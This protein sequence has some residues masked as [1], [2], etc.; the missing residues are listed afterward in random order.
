[1]ALLASLSNFLDSKQQKDTQVSPEILA[2]VEEL[3]KH[4]AEQK[5]LRDEV[6]NTSDKPLDDLSLELQDLQRSVTCILSGL[7]RQSVKSS[8]LSD[9]VLKLE[10]NVGIVQRS[11][12]TSSDFA[13]NSSEISDYFKNC[14]SSFSNRVQIYKQEIQAIE[15]SMSSRTKTNLTPKELS[16]VIR[17]LDDTFM[18]LAAQL[19]SLHEELSMPKAQLIRQYQRIDGAKTLLESSD[20]ESRSPLDKILFESE[21][22]SVKTPYGPSPFATIVESASAPVVPAAATTSGLFLGGVSQ[23]PPAATTTPAS[24]FSFTPLKPVAS[25]AGSSF[26]LGTPT[27]ATSSGFSLAGLGAKTTAPAS[28]GFSFGLSTPAGV[29][30][31]KTMGFGFGSSVTTSSAG[32]GFGAPTSTST[33]SGFGFGVAPGSSIFGSGVAKPNL[34]GTK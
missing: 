14:I 11:L 10:R 3:K 18:F 31:S 22:K 30:S 16:D 8:R 32:F 17:K 2:V 6:T 9:E 33:T 23:Q 20:T 19:Y 29:T 21:K 28:T 12:D 1:M 26:G 7:R 5:R 15:T 4:L 25:A 27:P 34:F 13:Q 24:G